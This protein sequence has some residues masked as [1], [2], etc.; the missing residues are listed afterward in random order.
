MTPESRVCL[1]K[2]K[3]DGASSEVQFN[4]REA[5][6]PS[7]HAAEFAESSFNLQ[8]PLLCIIIVRLLIDKNLLSEPCGQIMTQLEGLF[9]LNIVSLSL[10]DDWL[11][12]WGVLP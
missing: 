7:G 5:G 6:F 9:P 10:G 8:C 4:N 12:A 2:I 3:R 11:I 1:N